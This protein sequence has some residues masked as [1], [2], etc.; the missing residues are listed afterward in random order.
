MCALRPGPLRCARCVPQTERPSLPRAH[1]REEGNHPCRRRDRVGA[2]PSGCLRSRGDYDGEAAKRASRRNSRQRARLRDPP[3]LTAAETCLRRSA[4]A[5]VVANAIFGSKPYRGDAV[6]MMVCDCMPSSVYLP[7]ARDAAVA[8][9]AVLR[10]FSGCGL[11]ATAWQGRSTLS[12]ACAS[13][14]LHRSSLTPSIPARGSVG[15]HSST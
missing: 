8:S 6:S 12:V 5:R 3:E 11:V 7:G 2:P 14:S 4:P 15:Q 10:R 1:T 9:H 13:L